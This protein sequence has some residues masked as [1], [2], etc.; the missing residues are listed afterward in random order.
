VP[1]FLYDVYFEPFLDPHLSKHGVL[2]GNGPIASYHTTKD[3][4]TPGGFPMKFVTF[5]SLVSVVWFSVLPGDV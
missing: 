2:K 5:V 3:G 1:I 4:L